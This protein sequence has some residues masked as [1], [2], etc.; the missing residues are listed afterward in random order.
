MVLTH[1]KREIIVS[2]STLLTVVS[3]E[4]WLAGTAARALLTVIC[5]LRVT[6]A[7]LEKFQVS[8]DQSAALSKANMS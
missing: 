5:M 6:A 4:I 3:T 1:A 8:K 2:D 7:G